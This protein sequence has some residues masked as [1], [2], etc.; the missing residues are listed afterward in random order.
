M[1]L[2]RILSDQV[3]N[4]IAAG[5]VVE[6]PVAV[7]KELVENSLDAGATRIEVEFRAGGKNLIRVEDN[8][9]GMTP[10]DMLLAI[11]RHATSKI[12]VADDLHR[13]R[14]FGFRG[15]ALP[16]IASVAR[17]T[18]RSRTAARELGSELFINGGKIV[19]QRDCG[20]SPGTAIEVAHL[21]NSV[22]VR[23]KFLKTDRTEAA[24][25][26]HLC[27]LL[28]VAHPAVAFSL[29]EDGR[30]V[31]RSP[32]CKT[33]RERVMEIF[34][35]D[36]ASELIDISGEGQGMALYG[37]IGR[38][39]TGRS[40]RNE[41]FTYVNQRPVDSRT[42]TFGLLESYHSYL[43]KGR[44][45][46]AFL[47][48]DIDPSAVDVNIHPSKR[49]VRFRD[50]GGVRR[51]VMQHVLDRLANEVGE[52]RGT[53]VGGA[54]SASPVP[55]VNLAAKSKA[56]ELL[57]K[58]AR[59]KAEDQASAEKDSV[60]PKVPVD[61]TAATG[62]TVATPVSSSLPPQKPIVTTVTVPTGASATPRPAPLAAPATMRPAHSETSAPAKVSWK[63]LG[64][65]HQQYALF[66][67]ASGFVTFSWRAALE[68]IL[69]ERIVATIGSGQTKRQGLL[70]PVACEFDPLTGAAV[71]EHLDFI[72]GIGFDLEPFG[73]HFFRLEAIPEWFDP[74]QGEAFVRDLAAQLRE[75]DLRPDKPDFAREQVA[76][77]AAAACVRVM[78]T[79]NTAEL[80]TLPARLFACK[81][82]LTD[83]RGRPTF[84]ETPM[85]DLRKR[86]QE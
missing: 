23:R 44:Y 51:F 10:D 42:L 15:E 73:R 79:P 31:F 20:M 85:N 28:A 26:I 49:E 11:E 46:L 62:Q 53:V 50:E 60:A 58:L 61:Q 41:L 64:L 1:S 75:R 63:L 77:L 69:F 78:D 84:I 6:R 67:T 76:R 70:F 59:I 38:P 81:N 4:Q 8:G 45:P 16:S 68:R 80:T 14:T 21:F 55:A 66:E 2:I 83:P 24:H 18:L 56:A 40:T 29:L 35:S 27:R 52:Q 65:S 3:A 37:L 39:A 54:S 71:A 33:L 34:G 22:P 30:E 32:P 82:P 17:F 13:V 86:F 19:H 57:E 48:V 7:V 47:F 12:Q 72:R 36:L 5:E 74:A 25:I 43:P 9:S